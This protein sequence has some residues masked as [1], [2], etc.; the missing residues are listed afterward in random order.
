MTRLKKM[1]LEAEV[2]DKDGELGMVVTINGKLFRIASPA[3]PA[4]V[5]FTL[6]SLFKAESDLSALNSYTFFFPEVPSGG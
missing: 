1:T 4:D 3:C 2:V 6:C 5:L